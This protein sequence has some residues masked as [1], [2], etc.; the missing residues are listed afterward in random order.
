MSQELS[1]IAK[2][3][4]CLDSPNEAEAIAAL[5]LARARLAALNLTLADF[6]HLHD[7][8][9]PIAIKPP[10]SATP[11]TPA[12][13]WQRIANETADLLWQL[14]QDLYELGLDKHFDLPR[15]KTAN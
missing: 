6:L 14:G 13:D 15:S 8:P 4:A 9:L 11:S 2:I 10:V 12:T 5:R 3:I 7:T 1:R